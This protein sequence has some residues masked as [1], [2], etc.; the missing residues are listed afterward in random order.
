MKL[1]YAIFI[2]IFFSFSIMYAER[3]IVLE[4]ARST[5]YQGT[6]NTTRLDTGLE[7]TE[8][9][10]NDIASEDAIESEDADDEIIKFSG[11]VKISI[12][13][14]K[15]SSSIFADEILYNKSKETLE[16]SGNVRYEYSSGGKDSQTFTGEALLFNISSREGVFVNGVLEQK[17]G[18]KDGDSY[19]I[20]S[21]VSGRD[22]SSTIAFKN[23]ELTTCDDEDPHWS[24]SA[25]RVWLL[26][27]NEIGI[28]NGFLKIGSVPL[29][30]IPFF[31][32]PSD[33]MIV[34]PVFG[35]RNREGYF[36]QTTTY[37]IGRKPL[38]K[39]KNDGTSFANFFQSDVLKE[40]R[41]EGLFLRNLDTDATNLSSDYLKI[42]GD[43][44][45]SQGFMTGID[46]SFSFNGF[47]KALSV[48]VF[49]GF[50]N[51]LYKNSDGI[52]YSP[53][54]EEGEIIYQEGWFWGVKIPLRIKSNFA[55]RVDK[56]PFSVNIQIPFI[57]DPFFTQDFLDR[58][59]DLNWFSLLTE[60]NTLALGSSLSEDSSYSWSLQGSFLPDFTFLRPF[61]TQI[62]VSSFSAFM[63]F[64]SKTNTLI[65]GQEALYSNERKFFYSELI[66][67]Q[68]NL[69]FAG[70]IIDSSVNYKKIFDSKKE[71]QRQKTPISTITN[72]F[73]EKN[74]ADSENT[75]IPLEASDKE[76]IN[77]FIPQLPDYNDTQIDTYTT[78][79]DYSLK[80]TINP[81]FIQEY[82]FNTIDWT[83]PAD[84]DPSNFASVYTQINTS[85][86]INGL[87]NLN[88][89]L[90]SINSNI[91]YTKVYQEHPW[92]SDSV[93]STEQK[94]N[95]IYLAD[96]KG[97]STILSTNNTVMI[98]PFNTFNLLKPT[99]LAWNFD[100]IL[101]KKTFDTESTVENP[102]W[103]I[104][105]FYWDKEYIKRH[106]ATATAGLKINNYDQKLSVSGNLD[107]LLQ[108]YSFSSSFTYFFGS[109]SASTR[110]YEK[111]TTEKK[112]NWDPLVFNA[113]EKI[114]SVVN[115][116]QEYTYNL[117]EQKAV[118]LK[119]ASSWKG[120]SASFLMSDTYS[121]TLSEGYG[122]IQDTEKKF[123]PTSAR[124]TYSSGS[125]PLNCMFWKNRVKINANIAS[126]LNF[127]LLKST[128]SSFTF[129]P[130][131]SLRISDFI[132]ITLSS[133]SKNA[134]IYKYYNTFLDLPIT[135]LG[136]TNF[137][138]DLL[139]SF[140][141]FNEN[142][143]TMSSFK[144]TSLDLDIKHYLHDWTMNFKT[145]IKPELNKDKRAYEFQPI[146]SFFVQWNPIGDI[147]TTVKSEKGEFK[148][149]TA[150]AKDN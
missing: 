34:H 77:T 26:P 107:P 129:T 123:I 121:Y 72:P 57:S 114:F 10:L 99:S 86:K 65:K 4:S 16:A 47:L 32:Y 20:N 6:K 117:E 101:L 3:T 51:I 24:I 55:A 88:K 100:S 23:A 43:G 81:S 19:L 93:Y 71:D 78:S 37:L 75:S 122:W 138:L 56:K 67:S 50:S 133:N 35:F 83:E 139:N 22:A 144:L 102:V 14:G 58:S 108:A 74:S 9:A 90:F 135:V 85:A 64:N 79:L 61:V 116:S 18:K 96:Y 115:V 63:T 62:A 137:F 147:K 128:E 69:A 124:F 132:D 89:G 131:L 7:Q 130:S 134:Q 76:L 145:S 30:Y 41:R 94:K 73:E 119:I 1:R 148:L 12:S 70:T 52:F 82:R 126:N 87:L 33:E 150:D 5:E 42:I 13:E 111:E 44:Y 66:K 112:W 105:K 8:G 53:Y 36:V 95:A 60:Q 80:W 146:I 98:Q 127:N 21:N 104:E 109:F 45:S 27:G 49:A 11:N 103:K 141:F 140:N 120:L 106:S 136:E 91:L 2:F 143:R 84:I 31:Y 15:S 142:Q 48:S 97:M 40:Q 110:L 39:T 68:A 25:S 59:E 113:N 54:N 28:L 17:T 118:Q 149:N 46:G 125:N 29:F 92:L 38:P